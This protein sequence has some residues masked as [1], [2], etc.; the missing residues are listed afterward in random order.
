M[1][2]APEYRPSKELQEI[3]Q[4]IRFLEEAVN[5]GFSGS[6]DWREKQSYA[7]QLAET[8]KKLKAVEEKSRKEHEIAV[9]DWNIR[10]LE[11]EQQERREEQMQKIWED[12]PI[13]GMEI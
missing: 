13:L 12:S 8:K 4:R 5:F 9:L 2:E 7:L 11:E 3:T 1:N 6:D 10:K